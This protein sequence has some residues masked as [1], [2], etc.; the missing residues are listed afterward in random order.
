MLKI[1]QTFSIKLNISKH[2]NIEYWCIEIL[3]LAKL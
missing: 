3:S 1:A 2:N